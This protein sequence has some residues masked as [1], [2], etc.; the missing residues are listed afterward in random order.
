MPVRRWIRQL[1]IEMITSAATT[2]NGNVTR[3]SAVRV[4]PSGQM[5]LAIPNGRKIPAAMPVMRI[6]LLIASSERWVSA[7]EFPP[8]TLGSRMTPNKK[9][10]I[11]SGPYPGADV[12]KL[13]DRVR[14]P[15]GTLCHH[16]SKNCFTTATVRAGASSWGTWPRS[17]NIL[18]WLPVIS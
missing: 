16:H 15:Y 11:L 9:D 3:T 1:Q 4:N 6:V 17:S 2:A 7:I 10:T 18:R 12:N 14:P 13:S 8:G 5:P